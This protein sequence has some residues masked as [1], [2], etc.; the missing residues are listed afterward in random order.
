MAYIFPRSASDLFIPD[1]RTIHGCGY[2]FLNQEN[3]LLYL[4]PEEI[5]IICLKYIFR[6]YLQNIP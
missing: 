2:F 1:E 3:E 5:Y 4:P 6:R